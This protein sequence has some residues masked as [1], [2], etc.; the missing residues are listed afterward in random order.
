MVQTQPFSWAWWGS[1]GRGCAL[2]PP[3]TSVCPLNV[4]FLLLCHIGSFSAGEQVGRKD[5]EPP[6]GAGE[7]LR[8]AGELHMK[9]RWKEGHQPLAL[10]HLSL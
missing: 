9:S 6:A 5:V 4:P 7:D 10:L 8:L 3:L 1:G 2:Q